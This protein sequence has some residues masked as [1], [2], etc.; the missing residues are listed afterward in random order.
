MSSKD[1]PLIAL[2]RKAPSPNSKKLT[3]KKRSEVRSFIEDNAIDFAVS[4]SEHTEI[5]KKNIL[6]ATL[7]CMHESIS[8]LNIVPEKLMIDGTQFIPYKQKGTDKYI[9]HEC[10]IKGDALY[11]SISAAS[12]LAKV[13]HDE[14]IHTLVKDNP[15]LDKYGLQ[16]NMGYGTKKHLDAIKEH[17]PTE[18]HRMSFAPMK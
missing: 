14:W 7:E 4:Y 16:T 13:Y 15:E 18:W 11:P 9:P 2:R 1:I 3:A 6:R 8:K 10:I 5:D 12:I 17:G